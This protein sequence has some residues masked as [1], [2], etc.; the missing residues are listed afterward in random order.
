M[1]FGQEL[2]SRHLCKA[3]FPCHKTSLLVARGCR[4]RLIRMFLLHGDVEECVGVCLLPRVSVVEKKG[5]FS[6]QDYVL[7]IIR[8]VHVIGYEVTGMLECC[9]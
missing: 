9:L 5:Q 6:L 2:L 3:Q 4:F 7:V 1:G 8:D